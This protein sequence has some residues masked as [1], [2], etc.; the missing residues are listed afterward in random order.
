[1]SPTFCLQFEVK[2]VKKIITVT[3]LCE[4]K[5]VDTILELASDK[6]SQ[7]IDITDLCTM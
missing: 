1:M 7:K 2:D 3:I 4:R 5:Y 6:C